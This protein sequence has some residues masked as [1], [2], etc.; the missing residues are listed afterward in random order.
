MR[1][2]AAGLLVGAVVALAAGRA[3]AGL[4]FGVSPF[5][6]VSLLGAAALLAAAGALAC[7]GPARRVARVDPA[8]TLRGE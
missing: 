4:L 3:A 2:V 6:P 5:D 8:A 7:Y 1:P